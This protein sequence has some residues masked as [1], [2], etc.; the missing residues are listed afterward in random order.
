[1]ELSYRDIKKKD[2]I[3]VVDGS[4][5]GNVVDM[6]F[7]FPKG[8]IEGIVVPGRRSHKIFRFLNRNEVYIDKRKIVK[9]GGD[10]ILVDLKCGDFCNEQF[11]N[12]PPKSNNTC[13]PPP[14]PPHCPPPCSHTCS[15]S[16][17]FREEQS[18]CNND[19]YNE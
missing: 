19:T 5:L 18:F 12:N 15:P 2:V 9:I 3:N 1:M 11:E 4:C 13:C 6:V 17:G 14:C 10:V 16:F 8:Q 7:S